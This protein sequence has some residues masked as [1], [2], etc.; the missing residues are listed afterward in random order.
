MAG[1]TY[2]KYCAKC[3]L[4]TTKK[5]GP[6]DKCGSNSFEYTCSNCNTPIRGERV[7]PECSAT[8]GESED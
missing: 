5:V 7:C 3:K 2:Q 8:F 6:C 1:A 4:G